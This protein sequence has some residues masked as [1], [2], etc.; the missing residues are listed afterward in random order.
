M[1]LILKT[2]YNGPLSVVVSGNINKHHKYFRFQNSYLDLY[3][4]V[5]MDGQD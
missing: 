2:S 1:A 4:Y 3:E 5:P